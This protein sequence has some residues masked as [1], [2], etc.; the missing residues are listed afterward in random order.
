MTRVAIETLRLDLEA[1]LDRAA[2]GDTILVLRQDAVVA[3]IVP[4]GGGTADMRSDMPFDDLVAA[5]LATT[6]T[7]QSARARA[8]PGEPLAITLSELATDRAD[9]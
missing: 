7:P 2:R 3:R 8:A 4:A 5:G 6:P 1:Y 9:R